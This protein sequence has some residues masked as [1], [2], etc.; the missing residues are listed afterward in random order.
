MEQADNRT[1]SSFWIPSMTPTTDGKTTEIS[2]KL[3]P[4]CP[5]STPTQKHT[6]SLKTLVTVNF[7]K[8]ASESSDTASYSCPACEKNFSNASKAVI[9]IPC[10]HVLCKPCAQKFMSPDDRPPDPHTDPKD[11]RIGKVACFVCETDL[12]LDKTGKRKDKNAVRPG[13]VEIKSEGTGFAGG[14]DNMV[15]TKGT[16]FQC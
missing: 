12:T 2:V 6:L 14:G 15:K 7:K 10:G 3:H 8:R 11:D 9:A 1:R 4:L 16:A 5:L 13:I